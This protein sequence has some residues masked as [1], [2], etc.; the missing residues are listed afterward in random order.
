MLDK[1]LFPEGQLPPK[2]VE[3]AKK[4]VGAARTSQH[5]VVQYE[6][7]PAPANRGGR[8]GARLDAGLPNRGQR[9]GAAHAPP[10]ITSLALRH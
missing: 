7:R 10:S 5:F 2:M 1:T 8:R 4:Y 6:V 9:A 3:R